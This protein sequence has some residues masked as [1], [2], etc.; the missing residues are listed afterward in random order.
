MA[1]A[2]AEEAAVLEVANDQLVVELG[3]HMR[4]VKVV[5]GVEIAQVDALGIGLG[6]VGA[7]L[8]YV[9]AADLVN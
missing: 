3:A 8:L 4:R 9:H 2:V 7:I 6:T 5:D 1:V